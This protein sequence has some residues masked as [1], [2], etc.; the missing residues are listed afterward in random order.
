MRICTV[1]NYPTKNFGPEHATY[2]QRFVESYR[3]HPPMQDHQMIVVSNGGP[4]SG[5]AVRQFSWIKGT[6]FLQREN[7]AMDIGSYQFAARSIQC[8]MMV[9]FGGSSYFRG[10][11]WLMRMAN[12][13]QAY[14]DEALYGCTGN[15]GDNRQVN[16]HFERIWPHIR[17]TGFWCSPR[18]INTHPF[19]VK[20]N[21]ERYPYEHGPAGLTS[22]VISQGKPALVVGW[23]EIKPVHECDSIPNGFHQGDQSNIMVGDRLTAPPYYHVP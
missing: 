17:T 22:W 13:F 4:P 21:S 16:T 15:Q 7:V 3:Q 14:G 5:T 20:D 12:A 11:G 10:P 8:D 6:Q 9:F 1:Y 23:T 19:R 2:A 18:L